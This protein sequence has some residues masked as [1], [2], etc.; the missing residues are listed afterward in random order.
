[1]MINDCLRYY[2]GCVAYQK[3]DNIQLAPAIM[4]HS[5]VKSLTI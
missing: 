3:F 2:K 1:M 4:L 5:I